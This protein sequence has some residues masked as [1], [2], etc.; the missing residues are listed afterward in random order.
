MHIFIPIKHNSQRVHRKNFRFFGSEPLFKHTL[1]K[2]KNHDVYVDTD[3]Q[4]VYDSIRKDERL[5]HVNV[6]D[7]AEN[8][9]GDKV[10]V[11][12]LIKDFIIRYNIDNP[13]TQI[14][15]TSPFL[16]EKTLLDAQKYMQNYD[17]IVSCNTYNS[18]FW[19]KENYGFVPV[20]HNPVKMEQT[21]DLPTFYEENSA[22]YI[23]KPEVILSHGSRI[24][25]QPYFYPID[26]KQSIDIDTE[27]D[28]QFAI[29]EISE[30]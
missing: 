8:L 2:Y 10:S 3:S 27:E 30:N 20:N 26:K 29:G 7:R 19:R 23:F 14:H 12:A 22:F 6:Y 11:C 24:G 25:R 17:S 5:A 9:K 28:W 13:V 4:E 15:V 1:L 21:Q 16:K 18:R